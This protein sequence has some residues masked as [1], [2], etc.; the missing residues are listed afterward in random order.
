LHIY[1]ERIALMDSISQ[2]D[3]ESLK[4][5]NA[6]L[7]ADKAELQRQVKENADALQCP[8]CY[9]TFPNIFVYW[10]GYLIPDERRCAAC[11]AAA[12]STE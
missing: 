9:R 1:A 7:E 12:N 8:T 2:A 5:R 3:F 10:P 11:Y 4:A 6:Q